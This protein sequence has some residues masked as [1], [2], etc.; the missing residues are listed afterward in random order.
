[1]KQITFENASVSEITASFG[2]AR[3]S[4]EINSAR[5][6][7]NADMALYEAKKTRNSVYIFR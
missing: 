2:L 4:Q 3:Y 1:M 7:I 5:L 6:F